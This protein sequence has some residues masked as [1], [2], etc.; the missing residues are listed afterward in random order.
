MRFIVASGDSIEGERWGF[1]YSETGGRPPI[2][3]R[4]DEY[5]HLD[6]PWWIWTLVELDRRLLSEQRAATLARVLRR[7]A[8]VWGGSHRHPGRER[9]ARS[10]QVGSDRLAGGHQQQRHRGRTGV[11]F[12]YVRSSRIRRLRDFDPAH[13]P[14]RSFAHLTERRVPRHGS[15]ARSRSQLRA[16]SPADVRRS[17]GRVS[18]SSRAGPGQASARVLRCAGRVERSESAFDGACS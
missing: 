13:P 5:E 9:R 18:F 2:M 10:R 15:I 14:A 3:D 6:G 4:E 17:A 1:A 7:V 16:H 8:R 11:A 12:L